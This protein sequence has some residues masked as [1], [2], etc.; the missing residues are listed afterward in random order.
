[1]HGIAFFIKTMNFSLIGLQMMHSCT[2]YVTLLLTLSAR[3]W[4]MCYC[5]SPHILR[6]VGWTTN[7]S[8]ACHVDWSGFHGLSCNINKTN[9]CSNRIFVVQTKDAWDSQKG[10]VFVIWHPLWLPPSDHKTFKVGRWWIVHA[11]LNWMFS[12]VPTKCFYSD[13]CN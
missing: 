12:V 9:C 7:M 6:L 10:T 13:T 8:L 4:H 2:K 11:T 3:K 1:M 5:N